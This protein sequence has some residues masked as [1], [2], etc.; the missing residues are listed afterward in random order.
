VVSALRRYF[1]GMTFGR[2]ILWWYFI[3]YL[4]VLVRYFDPSPRLWLTAAGLSAIIGTALLINTTASGRRP[5]RLEHWPAVRLYLFPFCVSSFSSLVKGRDFILIFSPRWLDLL[6]TL[7]LCGAF[8]LI[9]LA[10]KLTS[11]KR[12]PPA[13]SPA[14]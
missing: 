13:Q 7:G 10:V 12:P 1:A 8:W 14:V 5:V 3:W 9:V 4:V 6:V 11:E 2:L